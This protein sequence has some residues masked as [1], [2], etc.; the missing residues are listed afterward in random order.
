MEK[1]TDELCKQMIKLVEK[2]DDMANDETKI[3][4]SAE[5]LSNLYEW[6]ETLAKMRYLL[7]IARAQ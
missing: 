2:I 7:T 5:K 3:C 1:V 6:D 4:I